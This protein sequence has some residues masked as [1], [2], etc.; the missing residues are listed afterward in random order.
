MSANRSIIR[1]LIADFTGHSRADRCQC[2][3]AQATSLSQEPA[4]AGAGGE[5]ASATNFREDDCDD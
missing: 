3:S 2:G 1:A 4:Q 5:A